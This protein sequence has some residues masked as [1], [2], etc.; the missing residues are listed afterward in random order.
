MITTRRRTL[1]KVIILGDSGSSATIGA[2]FLTKEL[3]YE[4]RLFTLQRF[5][6]LG[7]AFY[8]GA[9]FCVLVYDVNSAKSFEYLNNWR[10]EF[11]IQVCVC[12]HAIFPH[13]PDIL[14]LNATTMNN[15]I[16]KSTSE[17]KKNIVL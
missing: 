8:R 2:D 11:L 16:A 15:N 12:I 9:V 5:Q 17:K 3:Q 7:V 14:I 6:S 10:E 4:D 1:L 13:A